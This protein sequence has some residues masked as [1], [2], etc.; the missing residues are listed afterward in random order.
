MTLYNFTKLK[1]RF[2]S[3]WSKIPQAFF[4]LLGWYSSLILCLTIVINCLLSHLQTIYKIQKLN[5]FVL[6][7][8]KVDW[9]VSAL[10]IMSLVI[11]WW[12]TPSIITSSLRNLA[13]GNKKT[14]LHTNAFFA[15]I[16]VVTRLF[17]L[18]FKTDVVFNC[19]GLVYQK[20]VH[21]RFLSFI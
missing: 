20:A 15:L 14:N 9:A 3:F 18:F 17:H 6:G 8:F 4:Y 7:V 16:N 13:D 11:V 12:T 19:W 2:H 10:Y 5:L 1:S 21:H